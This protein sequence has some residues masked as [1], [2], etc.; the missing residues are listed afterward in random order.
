MPFACVYCVTTTFSVTLSF[1]DCGNLFFCRC[2]TAVQAPS[3]FEFKTSTCPLSASSLWRPT[4]WIHL[5]TSSLDP[6]PP[7]T[8]AHPPTFL[9]HPFFLQPMSTTYPS[10]SEPFLVSVH[11]AHVFFFWWWKVWSWV[12]LSVLRLLLMWCGH[13][14]VWGGAHGVSRLDTPELESHCLVMFVAYTSKLITH[15]SQQHSIVIT[16]TSSVSTCVQCQLGPLQCETLR[17]QDL[18]WAS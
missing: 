5:C 10:L 13:C 14:F 4:M 11:D 16:T 15:L 18:R 8:I 2:Y 12:R 3:G 1:R 7:I 6:P 9:T 17:F